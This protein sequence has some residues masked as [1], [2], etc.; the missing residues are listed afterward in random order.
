VL[1]END[2]DG[3]S[4]LTKRCFLRKQLN[5]GV[6]LELVA[7]RRMEACDGACAQ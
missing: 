4:E 6:S 1:Y 3:Y 7:H 2:V 5:E